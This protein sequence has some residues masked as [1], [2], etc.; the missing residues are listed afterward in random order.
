MSPETKVGMCHFDFARDVYKGDENDMLTFIDTI[1]RERRINRGQL[2]QF[3]EKFDL[4]LSANGCVFTQKNEGLFPQYMRE[5]YER[6]V[7]ERKDIKA[8]NKD[9]EEIEKEIKRL[10]KRLRELKKSGQ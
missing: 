10:E 7:E 5:I 3:I 8:L 6:R 4:V 1:G 9:N 2:K